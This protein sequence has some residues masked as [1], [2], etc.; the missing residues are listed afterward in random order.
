MS[1]QNDF[2]GVEKEL[3]EITADFASGHMNAFGSK[4]TQDAFFRELK[5]IAEIET[6]V[7]NKTCSILKQ[8]NEDDHALLT[9]MF[10]SAQPPSP[11]A[12]DPTN[13]SNSNHVP[14]SN[15]PTP[16]KANGNMD[17]GPIDLQHRGSLVDGIQKMDETIRSR[18]SN[19]SHSVDR[20]S[21]MRPSPRKFAHGHM[22]TSSTGGDGPNVGGGAASGL[23]PAPNSS[24]ND[25]SGFSD[26]SFEKVTE[27]FTF[28][29]SEFSTL[30]NKLQDILKHVTQLNTMSHQMDE[31]PMMVSDDDD[32]N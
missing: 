12:V 5:I 14:P 24:W 28:L 31:G 22:S 18:R 15:V 16:R 9:S 13:K 30:G 27:R 4:A 21:Q 8:G 6:Q 32:A 10:A 17:A 3:R 1:M 11:H 26:K 7:F 25:G 2:L 29:E 19:A 20:S 23:P